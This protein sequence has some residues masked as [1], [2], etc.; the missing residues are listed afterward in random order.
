MCKCTIQPCS[1]AKNPFKITKD[2]NI[3]LNVVQQNL[4]Q[5]AM[6]I[7]AAKMR[8]KKSSIMSEFTW[9]YNGNIFGKYLILKCY[10]NHVVIV[11]QTGK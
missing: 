5:V 3:N 1:K 11:K 4:F 7:T 10:L 9:K 6:Y 2:K 8:R